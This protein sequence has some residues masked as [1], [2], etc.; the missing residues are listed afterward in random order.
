MMKYFLCLDEFC[1]PGDVDCHNLAILCPPCLK[2]I[3]IPYADLPP[4]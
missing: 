1:I 2:Y 3:A 4:D